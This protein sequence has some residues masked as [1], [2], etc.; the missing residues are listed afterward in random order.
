VLCNVAAPAPPAPP[1]P[2][3]PKPAPGPGSVISKL[4]KAALILAEALAAC[5][6]IGLCRSQNDQELCPITGQPTPAVRLLGIPVLCVYQHRTPEIYVNDS[7]AQASFPG[8]PN[9]GPLHFEPNPAQRKANRLDA[10]RG[11][12]P[13]ENSFKSRDEYP[14]ASSKEGDTNTGKKAR[15][16][17]VPKGEQDTQ[18]G[19]VQTF[20]GRELGRVDNA[21]FYVLPVPY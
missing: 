13:C 12:P 5:Q 1:K 21:E 18:R 10:L 19:D 9:A 15:V 14:Y 6:R 17:C 3:T 20:Y 4:A 8:N 11:E 2:P 16:M 7:E